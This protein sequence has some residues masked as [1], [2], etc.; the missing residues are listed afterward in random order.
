MNGLKASAG[1]L[2]R[3]IRGYGD[4]WDKAD[5]MVCPPATLLIP[6]AAAAAAAAAAATGSRLRIGAQDC[7]A[8]AAGAFT[9]DISAEMLAD[10]GAT[11]VIV[12]VGGAVGV[13][14]AP[15]TASG[16]RPST[17]TTRPAGL[18][19][20]TMFVPSSTVQMLSSGSTRTLWANSKP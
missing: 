9:G 5:L 17:I 10:A 13:A 8:E 19:L 6:F 16:R 12:A 3:I 14:T 20:M 11:A 15:A 1:E 7:Y 2:D 18:N 4:L